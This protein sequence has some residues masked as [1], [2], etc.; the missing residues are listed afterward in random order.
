MKKG[1]NKAVVKKSINKEAIQKASEEA[2]MKK[3]QEIL[4]NKNKE[5]QENFLKDYG[6]ICK[7]YGIELVATSRLE[8]QGI[9]K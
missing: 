5:A 4:N 9:R 3:A 1:L 8:F 6:V 2:T 7:K